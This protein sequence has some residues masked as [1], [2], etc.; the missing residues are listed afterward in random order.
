MKYHAIAV[1]PGGRTKSIV[2]R[3]EEQ[4]FSEVVLPFVS[5]GVIELDWGDKARAYQ[6]LELRVYKTREPWYKK[7]GISLDE[8]LKSS[9]NVFSKFKSRAEKSLGVGAH[10][11][12]VI[13]PI[14]GEKYGTQD[15]QRIFREYDQRFEAIEKVL[16]ESKCVAIRID[17]EHPLD[18]VVSRIKQEIGDAQFVV[19]D[20]TDERPSCYFEAGYAE[21]LGRPIIY[22][23]SKESVVHPGV[24]TRVHFDVHMNVNSFSNHDEMCEKL[25][26][27]IN[28]NKEILFQTTAPKP[29]P[30][31]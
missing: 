5:S 31:E 18:E 2:N 14:Q 19:A 1:L 9:K 15:D 12:F 28:K 20:L 7:A 8:F 4:I 23:A 24:K 11:V 22:I 29:V 30:A 17:K 13:M 25:K 26:R 3:T 16:A 27:C 6:V 10:R 21:A